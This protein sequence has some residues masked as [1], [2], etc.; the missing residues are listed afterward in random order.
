[1]AKEM[2]QLEQIQQ[3]RSMMERSSR[4]ISL[5]GL[6]G[7]FA[8]IFALMGA[9]AFYIFINRK[10]NYGYTDFA[11]T[12]PVDISLNVIQFV[13]LDAAAILFFSIV[14]AIYFTTRKARSIGQTIW[15]ATARRMILSLAVPLIAGGIYCLVLLKYHWFGLIAPTTLIFYG[16][17][18][19][20]AG[21]HT[22]DEIKYLGVSEIV[23][24]IIGLFFIGYGITLWVIGFG[25]LHIIYGLMMY[26][27]YEAKPQEKKYW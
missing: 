11:K 3:I 7:V 2:D 27:R 4:F 20:N 1:M 25:I 9:G 5:S 8:G 14:F 21:K 10:L 13:I 19:V 15:D 22:L 24:G 16:L 12:I 18:L 26:A 17:A 23:L 6:A